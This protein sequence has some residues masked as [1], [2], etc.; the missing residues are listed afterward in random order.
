MRIFNPAKDIA[1]SIKTIDNNDAIGR[2]PQTAFFTSDNKMHSERISKTK[3]KQEKKHTNTICLS[4]LF[5]LFLPFI[6]AP[7]QATPK[8][9]WALRRGVLPHKISFGTARHAHTILCNTQI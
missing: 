9:A 3:K 1:P 5:C 6:S 7:N 2:V 4:H 8:L